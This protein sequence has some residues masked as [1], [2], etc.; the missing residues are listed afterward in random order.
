MHV[1]IIHFGDIVIENGIA[2]SSIASMRYRAIIPAVEMG[3]LG[4]SVS[5]IDVNR[6]RSV[7]EVDNLTVT[8]LLF[9]KILGLGFIS[10]NLS[11]RCISIA[12]AAIQRGIVVVVDVSDYHFGREDYAAL[13][14]SL[15]EHSTRIVT[16]SGA[17]AAA[18]GKLTDKE[19]VVITDPVESS[20]QPPMF[21]PRQVETFFRRALPFLF[22]PR[23]LKNDRFNLLWFG[24]RGNMAPLEKLF[25]EFIKLSAEI[26]I[27]LNI[28]TSVGDDDDQQNDLRRFPSSD[29]ISVM[30]TPWSVS[31]TWRALDVCDAVVIPVFSEAHSKTTKSP[32]RLTEAMWCGRFVFASPIPAYTRFS[33][34]A[35]VSEDLIAGMRWALKNPSSVMERIRGAQ[36]YIGQYFSPETIGKEWI[37]ALS[38]PADGAQDR[39]LNLQPKEQLTPRMRSESVLRLNLGCGDKILDDYINVDVA[40]SRAGRK[41]DIIC[42]LHRLSMFDTNSVDEILSIHVIEHFWRWEVADILRE[43]V[44][45]LKPGG[46]LILE[47]PNLISACEALLANPDVAS[48]EGSEGQ[49]SMWVFY[50]DP[51]WQDPL[52]VHR[53]GYTPNSL[54]QLLMQTGLTRVRREPAQFKLREPRDM[55]IVGEKHHA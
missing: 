13:Y 9:T 8:Q 16:C 27:E 30:W 22:S 24:H 29:R 43:W 4:H 18:I 7:E 28:V 19:I 38:T 41:P 31:E 2:S 11:E 5:Y 40:P 45:V 17:L 36:E 1:G 23:R 6:I 51:K 47:C 26:P 53:W 34:W 42:D 12:R 39:K 44:R 25:P 54:I 3:K 50:G 14:L 21:A 35:W 10:K 32:N 20:R 55:R 46:I 37:L 52:M 48:A 15:I 49:R 33:E